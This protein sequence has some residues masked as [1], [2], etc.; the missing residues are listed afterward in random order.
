[1]QSFLFAL[2]FNWPSFF[3]SA[4]FR[5]WAKEQKT[6]EAHKFTNSSLGFNFFNSF[7]LLLRCIQETSRTLSPS[8][9]AA[10]TE[11]PNGDYYDDVPNRSDPSSRSS[12]HH[13]ILSLKCFD[14]SP[15]YFFLVNPPPFTAAFPTPILVY[16]ERRSRLPLSLEKV[17][18]LNH[19]RW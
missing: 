4:G 9:M 7:Y 15:L 6:I 8:S 13:C 16:H 14:S 2:G 10:L 3:M 12:I 17:I 1:M 5:S 19:R 11:I 18:F